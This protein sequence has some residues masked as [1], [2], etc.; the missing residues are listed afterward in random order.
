M[1]YIEQIYK[2]FKHILARRKVTKIFFRVTFKVSEKV[3]D[4]C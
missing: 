4:V 3:L 1:F 2:R